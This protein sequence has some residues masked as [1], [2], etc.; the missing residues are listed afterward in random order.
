MIKLLFQVFIHVSYK[1][2]E[3]IICYVHI[4]ISCF[5][6]ILPLHPFIPIFFSDN[7]L[8]LGSV[9]KIQKSIKY[10]KR[11]S[12]LWKGDKSSDVVLPAWKQSAVQA[13]FMYTGYSPSHLC[14]S[15]DIKQV[16]KLFGCICVETRS[17]E[18]KTHDRTPL[19]N[20]SLV[21][22]LTKLLY[23][24]VIPIILFAYLFL[25]LKHVVVT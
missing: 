10:I 3:N 5:L 7:F 24:T 23:Y 9:N 1:N 4:I 21:W 22:V 13:T 12:L 18:A 6:A 19:G 17:T 11:F 14:P 25:F 8:T 16:W 2:G 20:K 15:N